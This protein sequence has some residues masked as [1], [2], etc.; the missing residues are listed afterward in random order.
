M[1]RSSASKRS[2]RP[3]PKEEGT[4]KKNPQKEEVLAQALAQAFTHGSSRQEGEADTYGNGAPTDRLQFGYSPAVAE[5]AVAFHSQ[6][7]AEEW[8]RRRREACRA[9]FVEKKE[10]RLSCEPITSQLKLKQ[11]WRNLSQFN[12][13]IH[14]DDVS[15]DRATQMLDTLASRQRTH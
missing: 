9:V 3:S 2:A 11:H 12:A 4:H 8:V 5:E 6:F 13:D 10:R 15:V 1:N 7:T 14:R